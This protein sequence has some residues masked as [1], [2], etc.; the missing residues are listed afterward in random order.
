MAKTELELE[1]DKQEHDA[2][3][4]K[5]ADEKQAAID[6]E[7]NRVWSRNRFRKATAPLVEWA[8]AEYTGD[9]RLKFTFRGTEYVLSEDSHWVEGDSE[10]GMPDHWFTAIY[11]HGKGKEAHVVNQVE[12]F[13]PPRKGERW[14]YHCGPIKERVIACIKEID[15]E[16]E[17]DKRRR[18]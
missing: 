18:Y 15:E 4:K 14:G 1:I 9:T 16:V 5:A 13:E 8:G 6:A 12:D 11:L 17:R 3:K 10:Q 7:K 2:A